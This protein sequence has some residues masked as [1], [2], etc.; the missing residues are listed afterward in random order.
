MRRVG[1]TWRCSAVCARDELELGPDGAER[2]NIEQAASGDAGQ[3]E[4]GRAKTVKFGLFYV[5]ECPDHDYLRAYNEML[6]QIEYAESLGF[7]S[8]WLAEHHGDDYGSMPSPQIAA[9]A[10]A[11]RTKTMR[12]GMAVSILTFAHPLRLAEDWAMVDILSN[13][14]LDFGVGRGYQ[15]QE[16]KMMGIEQ[17]TSRERFAEALDIILG[18]WTQDPFSYNGKHFQVEN[19]SVR[20]KVVQKPHPPVFVAAISPETFELVAQKGLSMLVTPTLMALPELKEYVL[21]SKKML[22]DSG[23]DPLTLDFPMNL[24]M[25]IAPTVD[26]ARENTKE[27]LDWYFKRVMELV[28]KGENAPSTYQRYAEVAAQFDEI[29]PDELVNVLVDGGIILLSDPRGAIER[30]QELHDDVG[31]QELLCWMRM[32][33][34]EHHKVM[35]SIKLFADEVMPYFK[36]Q[37]DAVPQ[38]LQAAG[39]QGS[40]S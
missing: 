27:A 38:E 28:P 12:I 30:I 15:P 25:H 7:D 29:P 32:G 37:P 23:R 40:G 5:L 31:Q 14:R 2:R 1:P 36:A 22:V 19:V 39:V 21:K 24:Q 16:F 9:A 33:G 6:D 11:E 17:S 20:P 8:V 13:G 35:S 18:A 4:E 10:I 3:H 34:L 26:E